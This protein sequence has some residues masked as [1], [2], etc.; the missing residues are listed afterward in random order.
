MRPNYFYMTSTKSA[1]DSGTFESATKF[2]NNLGNFNHFVPYF[3]CLP[4]SKVQSTFKRL[5]VEFLPL[6]AVANILIRY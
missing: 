3:L 5:I 4:N 2:L 1:R 6:Y